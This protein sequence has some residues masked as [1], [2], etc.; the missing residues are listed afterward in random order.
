MGAVYDLFAVDDPGPFFCEV[1]GRL[2]LR[3]RRG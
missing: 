2:G 1:S 3:L